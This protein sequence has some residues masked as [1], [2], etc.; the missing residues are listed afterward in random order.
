MFHMHNLVHLLSMEPVP[1]KSFNMLTIFK[2]FYRMFE[3]AGCTLIKEKR[4]LVC[5]IIT[6]SENAT[7]KKL[8]QLVMD[9]WCNCKKQ[10]YQEF[11]SITKI[12]YSISMISA[13]VA[14]SLKKAFCKLVLK[15]IDS[16]FGSIHIKL[17][18]IQNHPKFK[19]LIQ[20]TM[21]NPR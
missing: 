13:N 15:Q 6:S 19:N 8:L 11:H 20:S 16:P 7:P 3:M 10:E 2:S 12:I 21:S 4:D 18:L 1:Y 14:E 9:P 5:S 17:K